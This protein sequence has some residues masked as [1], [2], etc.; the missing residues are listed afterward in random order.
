[1]GDGANDLK[2]MGIAGLSVAFRAKPVVCQQADVALN[3]SGLD[4]LLNILAELGA[5]AVSVLF[6]LVTEGNPQAEHTE[7]SY[8]V[9]SSR[10]THM[11][12]LII[13]AAAAMLA[14]CATTPATQ[15]GYGAPVRPIAM[16]CCFRDTCSC[17]HGSACRRQFGGWF[18]RR[19]LV[20]R[21]RMYSEPVYMPRPVYSPQP[22]Y[23]YPPVSLSLGFVFGRHWSSGRH[24]GYRGGRRHR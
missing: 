19:I 3:F 1:M 11:K 6:L 10:R 8:H 22:S 18:A 5:A 23:Y 13:I 9:V 7:I 4:G 2:M 20:P 12:T 21:R 15:Y 24:H 16:A 14:G 17:R